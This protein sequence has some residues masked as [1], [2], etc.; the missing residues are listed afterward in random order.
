MF[1]YCPLAHM[2][3][4]PDG[5]LRKLGVLDFASG[6]VV[7]M[8]AGLAALAGALYLGR[9]ETRKRKIAHVPANLTYVMLGTGLLWFGWFGFNA[10][11]SLG[12]NSTSVL[13]FLTTN[14][15]SATALV[16]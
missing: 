15:A 8:S 7:H 6:A 16:T 5:L 12:A 2:T 1:I 10:G 3:W 13:A 9:R 4:H 11:S 14:T